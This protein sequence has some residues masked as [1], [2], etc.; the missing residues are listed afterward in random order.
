[1]ACADCVSG[2]VHVGA[3]VGTEITLG[4][5]PTYATGDEGSKR[6]I[7]I[8]SD[9]F[10]WKL[11]NTRILADEYAARG[12]RVY[13]PNLFD[14]WKIPQWTLSATDPN[15]DSPTLLQRAIK[16]L[17]LFTMVPF[18]L[19]NSKDAQS[20]K[21]GGI[22][23]ELRETQPEA[24][25]GFVGFCWGGRYAITMNK[26]FDATVAAH[27]SLVSFPKEL[28]GITKP[29]SFAIA[30]TDD[31]YGP[32]HAT[33]TERILKEKGLTDFEVVVYKG[34]NHGWTVRTNMAIP[35]KKEKRDEAK[36]QVLVWFERYLKPEGA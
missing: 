32:R 7:V 26:D 31:H 30:E 23:K 27:P 24:K 2:S 14:G 5:L 15:N 8:G 6:I 4:G 20:A 36:E 21:I 11:V 1:M 13:L 3:P 17:F 34:V 18:L 12:F 19:R 22:L 25:V 16:P 33:E 35:E 28:D 10:G 29:I 9:I